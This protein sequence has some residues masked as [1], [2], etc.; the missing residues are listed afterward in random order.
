MK[1]LTFLPTLVLAAL[2][3]I[4]PAQ[5]VELVKVVSVDN[6]TLAAQA[7]QML[8]TEL[9]QLHVKVDASESLNL[10]K[11]N[12]DKKAKANQVT[13]AKTSSYAINLAE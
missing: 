2:V 12:L 7:K 9:K 10:V 8:S 11:A 3:A 6:T 5:A 1:K 4:F 13:L